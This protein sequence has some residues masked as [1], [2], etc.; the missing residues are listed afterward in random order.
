MFQLVEYRRIAASEIQLNSVLRTFVAE[1]HEKTREKFRQL[2][3][4]LIRL[5]QQEIAFKIGARTMPEGNG[6]GPRGTHTEGCLVRHQVG[7]QKRQLALRPLMSRALTAVKTLKPCFMMSPLTV[8]QFL[9]PGLP[10][11]DVLLMDEAS[12]ILPEDALVR[13]LVASK[14]L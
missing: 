10:K 12:Q 2:D 14:L 1:P 11:F 3:Q 5:N 8:A 4:E 13:L 9:E 7:L 6:Y